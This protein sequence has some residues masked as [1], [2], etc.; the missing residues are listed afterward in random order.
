MVAMPLYCCESVH[1]A[2]RAFAD[3]RTVTSRTT[4]IMKEVR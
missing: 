4:L 1:C 3:V 2:A